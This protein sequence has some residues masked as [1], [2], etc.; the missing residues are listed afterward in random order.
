MAFTEATVQ[1]AIDSAVDGAGCKI[2]NFIVGAT[3]TDIYVQNMGTASRKSGWTQVTN[4][5]TASQAETDIKAAL[6][7]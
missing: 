3:T 7:A 1:A 2:T 6:S 4:T 5:R